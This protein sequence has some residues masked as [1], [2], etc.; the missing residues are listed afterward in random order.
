GQTALHGAAGFGHVDVCRVL[1]ECGALVEDGDE[2]GDTALH[3]AAAEGHLA[4][5][6]VL[7]EH[8]TMKN[9]F[10]TTATLCCIRDNFGVTAL[11]RAADSGNTDI[12]RLLL[13][14]GAC[15]D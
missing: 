15:M 7:L 5:V 11:H 13:E 4:V 2:G 14:H 8:H 1:L 3:F 6:R 12:C 10:D 9:G